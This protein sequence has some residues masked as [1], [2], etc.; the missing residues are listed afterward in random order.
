MRATQ[1]TNDFDVYAR[2]CPKSGNFVHFSNTVADP[3]LI[4]EVTSLLGSL[5]VLRLELL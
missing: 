3:S 5:H 1:T 2:I 4:L